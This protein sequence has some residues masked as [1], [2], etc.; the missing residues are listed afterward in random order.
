MYSTI[1]CKSHRAYLT[2]LAVFLFFLTACDPLP[3]AD[4]YELKGIVSA[5]VHS[6]TPPHGWQSVK[7]STSLSWLP[8]E[9]TQPQE[10]DIEFSA[11]SGVYTFWLLSQARNSESDNLLCRVA[12]SAGDLSGGCR[13]S[14]LA[15]VSR[16]WMSREFTTGDLITVHLPDRGVYRLFLIADEFDQIIVD[17]LHLTRNN[18]HPPFRFGYPLTT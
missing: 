2:V 18:E 1:L 4:F 13:A 11:Y 9:D 8:L 6:M 15:V 14:V 12:N 16:D 10:F 17:K 5:P 3:E 7:T